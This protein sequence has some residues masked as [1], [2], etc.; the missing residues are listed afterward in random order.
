[1]EPDSIVH[2]PP[3]RRS[4]RRHRQWNFMITHF[5]IHN[6]RSSS[7]VNSGGLLGTTSGTCR[8]SPCRTCARHRLPSDNSF[9]K[10][11]S[12]VHVELRRLTHRMYHWRPSIVLYADDVGKQ[13]QSNRT[14][15][16]LYHHQ[17]RPD[18]PYL[19]LPRQP[20]A[21]NGATTPGSSGLFPSQCVDAVHTG[22]RVPFVAFGS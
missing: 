14:E 7:C 3:S 5:Q 1:M 12:K 18:V 6:D 17:D 2:N 16:K 20:A 9:R 22:S 8:R 11:G 19:R 15:H 4:N 13:V 21:A 10:T